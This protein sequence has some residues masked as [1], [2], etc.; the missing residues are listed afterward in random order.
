MRAMLAA[1]RDVV[2]PAD[3][4]QRIRVMHSALGSILMLAAVALMHLMT[5]LGV[6]D[7]AGLA[8]WTATSMAGLFALFFSIRFGWSARLDD[9]SLTMPQMLF[10]VAC[11]A[12]AYRVAG[13]GHGIALLM[14]TLILMFGMF[15]LK[16]RQAWVV[17]MYSVLAFGIAM[18]SGAYARPSVYRPPIQAIYFAMF[19]VFVCG[20]T[21]VSGRVEA[22]RRRLRAQRQELAKALDRISLLATHDELTGLLNRRAMT[23]QL[24]LERQRSLRAGHAWSVAILDVDHFKRVNDLNGHAGGDQA[25]RVVADVCTAA[26][27]K[28]DS[29]SRWGGEEFVMLFR[30]VDP[31]SAVAAVERIRERLEVTPIEFAQSV[32]RVTASIGIAAYH[33]GEDV[34]RVLSNADHALYAAKQAGRNRVRSHDRLPAPRPA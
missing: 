32:F 4:K 11:A 3:P 7:G 13:A 34:A 17:A 10:S 23:E 31:A 24:Q 12:W 28:C 26:V 20:L 27:R 19:V 14:V 33:P 9:P 29:V 16:P 5:R 8:A 25:L 1:L 15:G 6:N 18:A 21:A 30:D 2:L 22:M